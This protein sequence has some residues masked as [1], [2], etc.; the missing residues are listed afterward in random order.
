MDLGGVGPIQSAIELGGVKS[1][2]DFGDA[3]SLELGGLGGGR[4]WGIA[5]GISSF[6]IGA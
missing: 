6:E 3:G 5:V 4:E 2:V 1:I